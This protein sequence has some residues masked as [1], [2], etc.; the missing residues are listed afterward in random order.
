MPTFEKYLKNRIDWKKFNYILD[1]IMI[2]EDAGF[3]CD[4]SI[5]IRTSAYVSS[6]AVYSYSSDKGNSWV[7]YNNIPNAYDPE[8][9]GLDIFKIEY[10]FFINKGDE[11]FKLPDDTYASN[12]GCMGILKDKM[13]DS[14]MF[15]FTRV[16]NN[17]DYIFT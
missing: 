4:V 7:V 11:P 1:N 3:P 6:L 5:A 9:R 12:K 14:G 13:I 16:G 15:R 2:Y 10:S 17:K 8:V